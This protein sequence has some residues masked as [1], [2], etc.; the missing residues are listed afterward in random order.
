MT[1]I[2]RGGGARL[3]EG[4]QREKKCSLMKVVTSSAHPVWVI[5]GLWFEVA[6]SDKQARLQHLWG[7]V[8]RYA[9]YRLI[10]RS[11]LRKLRDGMVAE[12]M[13]T[14]TV[15][16]ALYLADVGLA[17]RIEANFAGS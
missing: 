4:L 14:E 8:S 2:T 1:A 17:F 6:L 3:P 15:C 5:C 9:H 16:R 12:V 11:R 10:T 7:N 13:E